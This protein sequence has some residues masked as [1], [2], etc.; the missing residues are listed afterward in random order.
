[1]D[2]LLSTFFTNIYGNACFPKEPGTPYLVYAQHREK[3]CLKINR[4]RR[5]TDPVTHAPEIRPYLAAVEK[6]QETDAVW[7]LSVIL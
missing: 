3:P 6:M 5:L 1:M 4:N 2:N 7:N